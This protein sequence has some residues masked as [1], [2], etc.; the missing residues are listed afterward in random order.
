MRALVL[1][2]A[3]LVSGCATFAAETP[4]QRAFAALGEYSLTVSAAAE[5]CSSPSASLPAC[6]RMLAVDRQIRPL[7]AELRLLLE[8]PASETRDEA[9]IDLVRAILILSSQLSS[10]VPS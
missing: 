9:V 10:E 5:Y 1:A 2:L 7:V 3:L 4:R 8:M 6:Q